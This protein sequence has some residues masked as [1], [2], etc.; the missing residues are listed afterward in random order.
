MDSGS[1]VSVADR[2]R[3]RRH[4][5]RSQHVP[6]HSCT[7]SH[8]SWAAM[9][10]GP[11]GDWIGPCAIPACGVG[12]RRWALWGSRDPH[13]WQESPHPVRLREVSV[14]SR[15]GLKHPRS[16][17]ACTAASNSRTR[18][19][20]PCRLH[21][22]QPPRKGNEDQAQ[23]PWEGPERLF[24]KG[25][26]HP[27]SWAERGQGRSL[28]ITKAGGSE[29]PQVLPVREQTAGRWV[30]KDSGA[31]SL[32]GGL[33]TRGKQTQEHVQKQQE[34][35]EES[36]LPHPSGAGSAQPRPHRQP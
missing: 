19:D 22:K 1:P 26:R 17:P 34:E 6:L 33:V 9:R 18:S 16:Q 35:E 10:R 24:R 31:G 12:V 8:I 13:L 5:Q 4:G 14:H 11:E 28:H 30:A 21:H 3:A 15:W 2:G 25:S 36:E 7:V 20:G 32:E 23:G 29:Y 27:S